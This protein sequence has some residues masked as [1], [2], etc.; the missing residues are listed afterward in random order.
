M[1]NSCTTQLVQNRISNFKQT[2]ARNHFVVNC[3]ETFASTIYY[4]D[5][6]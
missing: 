6:P 5:A 1:Y 3:Y 4:I 2:R